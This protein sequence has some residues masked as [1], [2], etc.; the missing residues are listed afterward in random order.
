MKR[1][2]LLKTLSILPARRYL[3]VTDWLRR[4]G[5]CRCASA[6][7]RRWRESCSTKLDQTVVKARQ[8]GFGGAVI[9]HQIRSFL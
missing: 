7:T 2:T 4:F 5:R 6:K 3:E 8:P 1:A 9:E